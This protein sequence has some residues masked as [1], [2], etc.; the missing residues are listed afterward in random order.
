MAKPTLY[1]VLNQYPRDLIRAA[2]SAGF[3]RQGTVEAMIIYQE[4]LFWRDPERNRPKCELYD[5][6]AKRYGYSASSIRKKIAFMSSTD[7]PSEIESDL[8][9]Y[10]L[11]LHIKYKFQHPEEFPSPEENCEENK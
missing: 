9:N 10:I 11:Y 7:F 1:E 3:A 6:L 8:K 2:E 4:F 5:S